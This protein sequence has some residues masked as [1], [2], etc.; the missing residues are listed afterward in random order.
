LKS[1]QTDQLQRAF[2]FY[3]FVGLVQH[4]VIA[5][6]PMEHREITWILLPSLAIEGFAYMFTILAGES[7]STQGEHI[8]GWIRIS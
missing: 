5:E 8:K 2:F 4:F 3:R 1:K 6:F 7:F